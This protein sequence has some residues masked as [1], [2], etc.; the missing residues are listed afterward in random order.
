MK[1]NIQFITNLMDFSQ[2]GALMQAFILEGLSNYAKRVQAAPVET[3]DS[4]MLNGYAWKACA[5]EYLKKLDTHF[6]N[7]NPSDDDDQDA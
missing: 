2:C 4:P 3:F 6:S 7:N 1:T 5:D